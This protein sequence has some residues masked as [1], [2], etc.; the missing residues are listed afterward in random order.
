MRYDSPQ[1]VVPVHFRGRAGDDALELGPVGYV[2]GMIGVR[3]GQTLSASA[4]LYEE[5]AEGHDQ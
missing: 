5:R 4:P 3:V 2:S 1:G